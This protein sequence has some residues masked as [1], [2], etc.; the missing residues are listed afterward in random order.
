[1]RC[2]NI[3]RAVS[4]TSVA[5]RGG[6]TSQR[7]RK[8]LTNRDVIGQAKGMLMERFDIDP[9]TAFSVLAQ[10]SKD[11]GQSDSVVARGLVLKRPHGYTAAVTKHLRPASQS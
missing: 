1:M 2:V 5:R 4:T 3:K 9:V 8:A 7:F 6:P 11:R 10:L